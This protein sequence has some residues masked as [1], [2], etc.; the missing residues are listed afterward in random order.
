V[1]RHWGRPLPRRYEALAE[2]VERL[3]LQAADLVVVVSEPLRDALLAAG[4]DGRR[5][6]VNPNGVDT[7]CY[8][9]AVDGAAVRARY[10]L[11]GKQVV[12]FIG[13]FGRWHG[14]EVLAE[15]FGRL[16]QA[17][18]GRR[19]T[20]RLLL[21]GDGVTL[22]EAR[23]RLA[24][25][26]VGPECVCTGLVPQE[27][28][29]EHLAACDVLASPHVPNAD[30]TEFFGSPTKLF[31][32]LAMGRAVVASELGQQGRLL[33]HDE[34]AWLVRAGDAAA[35]AGALGLLLGDAAR[36]R[37]LGA[38]ARREAVAHHTW[39]AHTR[40]LLDRLELLCG[41]PAQPLRLVA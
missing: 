11:A 25:W 12:G 31:E 24:A 4:L 14:A 17:Q 36:R 23:A 15:A 16:L 10:G 33:R 26:G 29:P 32:Y 21:V 5:V 6:L 38:A 19:A 13:T 22:P 34:T 35:L 18:P 39:R 2:R 27:R 28:G 41:Q 40:R 1:N 30:G 7:D 37:R 3:N 9:P 20:T 8:H